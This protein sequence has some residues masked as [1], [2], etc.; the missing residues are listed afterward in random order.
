M[1]V[2]KRRMIIIKQPGKRAM[3]TKGP[4]VSYNSLKITV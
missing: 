3:F 4:M 2:V 1:L